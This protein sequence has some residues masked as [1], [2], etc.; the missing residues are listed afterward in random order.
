[1]W[2]LRGIDQRIVDLYVDLEISIG[3][4]VLSGGELAVLAVL[5][6]SLRFCPGVLGN[7]R[8][9]VEDSFENGGFDG[10]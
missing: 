5:D 10:L 7:D 1:M 8:S 3:D 2:S 9:M 4:F 6:S